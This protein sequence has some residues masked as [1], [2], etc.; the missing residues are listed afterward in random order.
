M[1]QKTL[2]LF[3]TIVGILVAISSKAQD[4]KAQESK[5]L[6]Y[7]TFEDFKNNKPLADLWVSD[8]S[9]QSISG[10]ESFEVRK[11]GYER[12]R[13]K[14]TKLPAPFFAYMGQLIRVDGNRAYI[15]L[16][17]GAWC[18]FAQFGANQVQTMS[19]GITGEMSKFKDSKL[20]K[21]L[22]ENGLFD[23]YLKDRPKREFKDDVNQYFNK[24]VAWYI[25]YFNVLNEKLKK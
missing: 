22:K 23:A 17:E 24:R 5:N 14:I 25:Q 7:A 9:W 18:Y 1:V 21:L 3:M 2:R 8:N 6:F 16:A 13:V 10:W 4:S 12:D 11:G 20:E 19:E 15:V